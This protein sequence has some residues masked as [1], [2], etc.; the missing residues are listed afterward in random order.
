[1]ACITQDYEVRAAYKNSL[2]ALKRHETQE[3]E[4]KTLL[5]LRMGEPGSDGFFER[6]YLFIVVRHQPR[7]T[8]VYLQYVVVRRR[9]RCFSLASQA[10]LR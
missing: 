10:A 6:Y 8:A 5:R 9:G 1:M 2:A 4:G 7:Y 3:K